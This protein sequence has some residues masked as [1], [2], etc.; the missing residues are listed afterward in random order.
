MSGTSSRSS[1]PT[2]AR[3]RSRSP[4]ARRS[5][6]DERPDRPARH[7]RRGHWRGL[8]HLVVSERRRHQHVEVL[9]S[10]RLLADARIRQDE[11]LSSPTGCSRPSRTSGGGSRSSCTTARCRTCRDRADARRSGAGDRGGPTR[12]ALIMRNRPSEEHRDTIRSLRD[13]SFNIEPVVLR[14]Q[15]IVPAVQGSPSNWGSSTASRST[16]TSRRPSCARRTRSASTRSSASRSA[17]RSCGP[18]TDR[19]RRPRG[20]RRRP[21][22]DRVRQRQGRAP[23]GRWTPSTSA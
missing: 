19:G 15:G 21:G 3:M 11:P 22:D 8:L 9:D 5:S 16:S 12:R 17:R 13:L 2:R 4:F 6:I 20:G 23:E 7:P 10:A 14:D 1:R 18:P